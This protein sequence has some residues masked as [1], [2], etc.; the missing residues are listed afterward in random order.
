MGMLSNTKEICPEISFVCGNIGELPFKDGIADRA[1]CYFVL[2]NMMDDFDIQNAI[3]DIMRI[4]K[5][6]GRAL[7]GQ[8]PDK[9][10]S[11]DYDK[12]KQEYLQYYRY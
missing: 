3:I 2:I 5:K 11:Y 9:S 4:L 8:L 7:I 1:L 10:C 12:S 6:G